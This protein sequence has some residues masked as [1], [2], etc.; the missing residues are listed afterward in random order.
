MYMDGVG[1]RPALWE[2]ADRI[3]AQG[4]F[5][6]LPDLYYRV[7]YKAEYGTGVFSH[8]EHRADLM[9]RIMPSASSANVMRD[10]ETVFQFLDGQ[11]NAKAEKIGLTGYCMGGR[12]SMYAAGTFGERIAG[13]AAY[14][15][16]GLATDSP[17]SPHLLA[18][19]MKAR[20]YVGGAIDD[21]S[22]DDE[23]KA[24]FD[25]ALTDAGVDHVIETY[26]AKH[27]FVP[28]DM[29]SYDAAAAQRHDETLLALLR[30]VL[31]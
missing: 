7:G 16:G 12:L 26:Q 17:D 8:P 20:I 28:P 10:T 24:R 19:K 1:M 29:P 6:V 14:H 15:P 25:K 23:Q 18:P 13:A 31:H 11:K 5:V 21:R 9:G 27:G 30:N 2:I 22:F 3:S 4:Y